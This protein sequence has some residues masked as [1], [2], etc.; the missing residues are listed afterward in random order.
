MSTNEDILFRHKV[1]EVINSEE[2]MRSIS[3]AIEASN[4]SRDT[5]I[6][7]LGKAMVKLKH[8]MEMKDQEH[9]AS[10]T[11]LE[12]LIK[13][14]FTNINKTIAEKETSLVR[15]FSVVA[16]LLTVGLTLLAYFK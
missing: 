11:R 13:N 14:N 7:N 2:N 16:F 5:N 6:S 15:I 12:E 1:S 8:A 3:Q 10:I 4:K 9:D